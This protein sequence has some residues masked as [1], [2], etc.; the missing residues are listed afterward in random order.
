M[1]TSVGVSNDI[2]YDC[3]R[4]E[5]DESSDPDDEGKKVELSKKLSSGRSDNDTDTNVDKMI[6]NV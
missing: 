6:V 1:D 4:S 2:D 5:Y 3:K